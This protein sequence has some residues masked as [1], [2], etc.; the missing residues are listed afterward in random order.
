MLDH[1]AQAMLMIAT[2]GSYVFFSR[3]NGRLWRWGYV[4]GLIGEPFWLYAS[5]TTGQWGVVGVALW[6]TVFLAIGLRNNWDK[7]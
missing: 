4:V 1:V 5:W 7:E 2:C 6:T 3:R